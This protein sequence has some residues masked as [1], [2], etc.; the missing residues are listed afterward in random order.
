MNERMPA[1]AASSVNSG[2]RCRLVVTSTRTTA[3]V[4]IASRH[5]PSPAS[6]W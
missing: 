2:H 5:G 3:P 1:A 6:Y 4:R